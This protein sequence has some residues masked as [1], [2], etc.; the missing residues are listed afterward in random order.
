[1]QYL[2]THLLVIV[3][4]NSLSFSSITLVH[5][6]R[7]YHVRFVPSPSKFKF[8]FWLVQKSLKLS[9]S[10]S[11]FERNCGMNLV[12]GYFYSSSYLAKVATFQ[13]VKKGGGAKKSRVSTAT[14]C[15]CACSLAVTSIA[16][17]SQDSTLRLSRLATHVS[18]HRYCIQYNTYHAPARTLIQL[19]F[20]IHHG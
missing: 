15:V 8:P 18:F 16:R 3:N 17:K 1:M 6:F 12:N 10:F 19:Y 13:R 20:P 4:L 14:F 2:Q 11:A 5:R 7:C 9:G